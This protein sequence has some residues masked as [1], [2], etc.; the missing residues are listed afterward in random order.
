MVDRGVAATDDGH[1]LSLW[2]SLAQMSLR[3]V[4]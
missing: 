2:F 1:L 3:I 4:S